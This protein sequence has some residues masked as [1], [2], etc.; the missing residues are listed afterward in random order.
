MNNQR[1]SVDLAQ[2]FADRAEHFLASKKYSLVQKDAFNA[3]VQCRTAKLGG[4]LQSC[5]S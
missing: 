3:I 1:T 5:D 4:H 2:I